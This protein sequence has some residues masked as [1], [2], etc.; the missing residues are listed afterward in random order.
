[1]ALTSATC[2]S[3]M[4]SSLRESVLL[5]TEYCGAS[6]GSFTLPHTS[7][8]TLRLIGIF[9]LKSKLFEPTDMTLREL[10]PLKKLI[11]KVGAKLLPKFKNPHRNSS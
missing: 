1:M 8:R 5:A 4:P 7:A 3:N 2:I 11:P 6:M 9:V 10:L